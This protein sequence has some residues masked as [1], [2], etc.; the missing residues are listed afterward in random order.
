MPIMR[1]VRSSICVVTV[2]AALFGCERA[3]V[4]EVP[5]SLKSQSLVAAPLA[6]RS[7]TGDSCFDEVIQ[8]GADTLSQARV[9]RRASECSTA[10]DCVVLDLSLPCL[11]LCPI[12]VSRIAREQVVG[13]Q[14]ASTERWCKTKRECE[15]IPS[16]PDIRASCVAG[17]CRAVIAHA[18]PEG[19]AL[20]LSDVPGPGAINPDAG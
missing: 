4:A 20:T 8:A 19:S 9:F 5:P 18:T 15:A 14:R 6:A 3:E 13:S 7:S 2:T 10:E 16:C 1:G 12:V 11:S 17:T